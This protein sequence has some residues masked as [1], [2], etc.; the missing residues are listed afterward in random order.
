MKPQYVIITLL[1]IGTSALT[2]ASVDVTN[3][4][5]S[6]E[7]SRIIVDSVGVA[8]ADGYAAIGYFGSL[9][10]SSFATSTGL[11]LQDDFN[12]LGSP[13]NSLTYT[14]FGAGN[15]VPGIIEF[16]A[17][18]STPSGNSFVGKAAFLVVGNGASLASSTEAFIF[19]TDFTFAED[20]SNTVTLD[21]SIASPSGSTELGF[22]DITADVFIGSTNTGSVDN[23]F[24]TAVLIPEPSTLLLSALGALALL[25]RKR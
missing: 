19:M 7:I 17:S 20:P 10:S 15:E 8:L 4:N 9:N 14:G 2:A 23:A 25:R 6:P 13:T 11:E 12:V 5:A 3:R 1:G 16:S 18:Q 22:D 24:Q 21:L